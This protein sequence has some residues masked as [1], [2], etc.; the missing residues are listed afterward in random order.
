MDRTLPAILNDYVVVENGVTLVLPIRAH[1]PPQQNLSEVDKLLSDDEIELVSRPGSV[2]SLGSPSPTISAIDVDEHGNRE[3]STTESSHGDRYVKIASTHIPEVQAQAKEGKPHSDASSQ[4]AVEGSSNST[5]SSAQNEAYRYQRSSDDTFPGAGMLVPI[6]PPTDIQAR[7]KPSLESP[8]SRCCTSH[9][10]V[11]HHVF[12][13]LIDSALNT[14]L[15]GAPQSDDSSKR[16][17][18]LLIMARLRSL[19]TYHPVVREAMKLGPWGAY[20]LPRRRLGPTEIKRIYQDLFTDTEKTALLLLIECHKKHFAKTCHFADAFDLASAELLHSVDSDTFFEGLMLAFS[21]QY[22]C[23]AQIESRQMMRMYQHQLLLSTQD[24]LAML[25]GYSNRTCEYEQFGSND[26]AL[27]SSVLEGKS[28]GHRIRSALASLFTSTISKLNVQSSGE[29]FATLVNLGRSSA[30]KREAPDEDI[31]SSAA[32]AK[33]PAK[34]LN[35]PGSFPPKCARVGP[36]NDD[37]KTRLQETCHAPVGHQSPSESCSSLRQ[38]PKPQEPSW[39]KSSASARA[40]AKHSD[41]C[42]VNA[43]ST[44]ELPSSTDAE[45][46]ESSFPCGCGNRFRRFEQLVRSAEGVPHNEDTL[47]CSWCKYPFQDTF[48]CGTG[49]INDAIPHLREWPGILNKSK[50]FS[51]ADSTQAEA[52]GNIEGQISSLKTSTDLPDTFHTQNM[53]LQQQNRKRL[54]MQQEALKATQGP[55][56][57]ST[58][59]TSED[60]GVHKKCQLIQR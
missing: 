59:V 3:G 27:P 4:P 43:P 9:I 29:D 19:P 41:T 54:M 39:S 37:L 51:V 15:R 22:D 16:Q 1:Y 52:G 5:S 13:L 38:A 57:G 7:M 35:M 58:V 10:E 56:V 2:R 14:Q 23:F 55:D 20:L 42:V 45:V 48:S 25:A 30:L 31:V 60:T 21:T 8:A 53:C 17:A 36:T 32:A 34:R 12:D 24:E 18:R 6:K 28:K 26:S 40:L 44:T 11:D 33:P 49:H 47:Y 50:D 46:L